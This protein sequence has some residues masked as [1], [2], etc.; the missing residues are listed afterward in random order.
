MQRQ[1]L[2]IADDLR[3]GI[4]PKGR[5]SI[6]TGVRTGT[7]GTAGTYD[8]LDATAAESPRAA[9][10]S[11]VSS[12][13]Q[14]D[15]VDP[16][17]PAAPDVVERDG[18]W[19]APMPTFTYLA[20][21]A[22]SGKTFLTKAHAEDDPGLLLAAT[23]GI[24]AINLGG[25]TINS[26]LG[27]FDTA[28]LQELYISGRLQSKLGALWRCGVTRIVLDEVS[29]LAGDQ[30]GFLVQAI[31]DVNNRSYVLDS[32]R[33][34]GEEDGP[35]P[36]LGLT[37]VGDFLQLAPVKATY[38]FEAE[39]WDRFAPHVQ[40]L[41]AVRRQADADFIAALRAAR[42]GR[43][44]LV[45][46]YFQSRGLIQFETDDRFE[47]PTILAKNDAVDRYNRL[48][49]SKVVGAPVR[50]PSERWGKQR[51]EW[52][53]PSKPPE[54]WGIPHT[55][56]LKIGA[57]VMVLANRRTPGTK[58]GSV[59]R[60]LVY[61]NGDLGEIVD[62]GTAKVWN[63]L[64]EDFSKV[65]PAAFVKLQRTGEVETVVPVEREVKI[66]CDSARRKE[67]M[68]EGKDDRIDGKWEIAGAITYM[69]LRIAYASTVHKSQGLS[70]DKVQVNIRDGFFKTPGMIY[71][72]LSRAR[73]AEGLRLVGSPAA[74]IERCTSDPRLARWR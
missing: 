62:V 19:A 54:T 39:E 49:L 2:P 53:N 24:A 5:D 25:E 14:A 21:A 71:V 42:E 27:Y 61:V 41:T 59:G 4:P 33:K 30:L 72:A 47:G 55:L 18:W 20:G 32:K 50:F 16:A 60:R 1:T 22:G 7:A 8:T 34:K 23:T 66:P 28:S 43:G 64:T 29:M 9:Q 51:S 48:R 69:P 65:V 56:E 37:L 45:V 73:T 70:L 58:D 46:E 26:V 11:R 67:L 40:T 10:A 57:L 35:P 6:D 36:Q 15:A 44:D 13:S 31:E 63:E 68:L 17:A 52:G 3:L 38:A 12:S 74:L